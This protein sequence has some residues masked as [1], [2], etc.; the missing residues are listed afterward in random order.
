MAIESGQRVEWTNEENYKFKL[1][2]F[3]DK[4][5]EWIDSNPTGMLLHRIHCYMILI[6]S[7]LKLLCHPIDA[8]KWYLG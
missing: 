5:L 4:L 6:A 7:I 1:S 3:Q 8:M 2:A